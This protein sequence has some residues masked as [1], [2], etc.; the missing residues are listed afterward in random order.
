MYAHKK[1]ERNFSVTDVMSI[2]ILHTLQT[3]LA[4]KRSLK[5]LE[6]DFNH[7]RQ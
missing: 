6:R 3:V 7:F 5:C 2:C 1:G 4:D